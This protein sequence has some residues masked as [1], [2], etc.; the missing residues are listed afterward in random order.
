MKKRLYKLMCYFVV[1][2]CSFVFSGCEPKVKYPGLDSGTKS[3]YSSNGY[4]SFAVTSD[5]KVE[6]P[7]E[8][9]IVNIY[10]SAL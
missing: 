5:L 8:E 1:V 10:Q 2:C 6:T 7:N 3:Y 4:L 9:D